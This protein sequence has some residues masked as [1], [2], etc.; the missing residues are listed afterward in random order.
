[1]GGASAQFKTFEDQSS[2]RFMTQAWKGKLAAGFSNS[3]SPSGDK[4]STLFQ[5][6]L[7]SQ[8]HGMLWQ[9]L[10]VFPSEFPSGNEFAS[11]QALNRLGS[12][13]GL[14]TQANN[15]TPEKTFTPGDL[16]TAE[17]FGANI[18]ATVT[19]FAGQELAAAK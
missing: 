9:G 5:I 13:A 19:K 18:A 11:K 3:G 2:T 14:M 6:F 16:E 17:L 15:D 4:L 12:F 7:F 10:G 8:Q 1:M